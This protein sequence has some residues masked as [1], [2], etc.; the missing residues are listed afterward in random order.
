M[1]G[2][3]FIELVTKQH[4][5]E[6]VGDLIVR[7]RRKYAHESEWRDDNQL[8]LW[9]EEMVAY[10]WLNDWFEGEEYVEIVGYTAVSDVY[11]W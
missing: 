11:I 6:Y 7:V 4:L 3:Q 1:Q 2:E 8:L 5:E 10:C 9:D